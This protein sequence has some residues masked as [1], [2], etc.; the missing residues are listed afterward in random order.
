MVDKVADQLHSVENTG[1]TT[2]WDYK[3]EYV[4]SLAEDGLERFS[5]FSA[6]PDT[7]LL[8]AGPARF[9]GLSG[10]A[11][12]LLPIGMVDGVQMGSN[13]QLAR[14]YEVGSSRAFFTRGK[15]ASSIS[16]SRMLAD[17]K[18]ILAALMA[19]SYKPLLNS[20]GSSAPGP[21]GSD[22]MMNFDSE[23]FAIPFGL[24]MVFKTKGGGNRGKILSA[25]YL[26]YCMFSSYNFNV[27]STS[28]VIP[29][30]V[31]IEFDRAVPVSFQ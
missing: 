29:E 8:F 17:K 12:A 19:N 24:L 1:F 3:T 28:P 20:E 4:G 9:T 14:L 13:A 18:N 26:E 11:A 16:F 10:D 7:T 30:S 21:E 6:T 23:Y 22:T 31:S 2:D 27:Q 15:T 5:Q 25:T